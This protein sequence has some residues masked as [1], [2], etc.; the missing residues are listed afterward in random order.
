MI[1]EAKLDDLLARAQRDVDD[2]LLPSCQ[3]AVGIDGKV[4]VFETFGDATNEHRYVIFSATKG[5]VA[6]AIWLLIGD[7][8]LDP[9]APVADTIEE[10]AA[11]DKHTITA[12][13]LLSH[14][15]G[16]PRA[17]LGP[18]EWFDRER[19]IERF[20]QWR[21]NWEPGTRCEYHGTSAHWV[22]GEMIERISG[23]DYRDFVHERIADALGLAA[24]RLGVPEAQQDDIRR[25][26]AV[27]EPPTDEE[28]ASLGLAGIEI[29]AE[30]NDVTIARFAD[31]ETIALGVPGAGAVS[32]ASDVALL[33][34][35]LLHNPGR[36]WDPDV[37]ADGTGN[38]RVR[39]DEPTVG[40]PANRTL[41]LLVAGDDGFAVNRG[42]GKT[43]SPRAFG[44][45]GAGGQLA[46]ADPATGL[47]FCYLT[48][49]S[50]ANLLREG[51][52]RVALS[53]RAGGL[54]Y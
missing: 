38:V 23:S 28:W 41:G 3:L 32:N 44:H 10:F 15:A 13:Q 47:S 54:V 30:I 14:T 46:W 21:L 20:A 9:S 26:V 51:R 40:G 37:L 25:V 45:S 29:P 27:G 43:N 16:I 39:F 6:A 1:D 17:P 22:L 36:I 48:D 34:Q 4:P 7:G 5:V 12:E 50:D 2:G 24:L 42:F 35:A 31:T 11:N 53:N 52:R 49:G 18:P 19:R 33:Y 8:L